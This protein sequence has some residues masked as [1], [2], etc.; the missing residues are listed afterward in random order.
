[1]LAAASQYGFGSSLLEEI[2][3]SNYFHTI[4]KSSCMNRETLDHN[5]HRWDSLFF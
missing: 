3:L 4:L 2:S 1:M 5:L